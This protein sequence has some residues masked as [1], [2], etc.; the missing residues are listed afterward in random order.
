M[1][2]EIKTAQKIMDSNP[3]SALHLLQHM[4][5]LRM[6]T[7]ADRAIYGIL[8]FQALDKNNKPLQPD[9][10][11]NFSVNY[12][13]A[14]NDKEH[15]ATAYYYKARLY[16]TAQQFD[17]ATMLYLKA[18]D[19]IQNNK[20]LLLRAKIFSD[21][22][23]ICSIQ[24]D[25]KE[26]LV[27]YKESNKWFQLAGDTINA[28]YKIIDVGRVYRLMNQYAKAKENFKN[29]LNQT[30]DSLLQGTAYQELGIN[31]YWAKK[32]DSA[33]YFLRKSLNYPYKGTNYSI[34][35]N[36]MA[37]LNFDIH[38]YDSAI[39]YA[40]KALK[41]PST[42][43]NQRDCY[44][45]LA[46]TEYKRGDFKQMAFY[47]THYQACSDSVRKVEVQTKTTVLE[48]IHQ[49][50]GTISRSKRFILILSFVLP[51][52]LIVS[53]FL[54]YTIRKR[55]KSKEKELEI[56]EVKLVENHVFL[57]DSL[58]QKIA[59]NKSLQA[60]TLKS[61][62]INQKEQILKEIYNVCLHLN[63]WEMFKNLM[64]KTYNNL[65]STLENNYPDLN[66]KEITCCCLF[67]L[68]VPLTEMTIIFESQPGSVY[69][70]KQRIATKLQL[71]SAKDLESVL[72]H[73]SEE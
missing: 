34:R 32:I 37:D 65:V 38:Q 25:Y 3:D 27:K 46:N 36:I 22:G 54:V 7:D 35:C 66:Q 57:K 60:A 26:S 40:T 15:L 28:C 18:L 53:V 24:M 5:P 12:Y 47:M 4:R 20:N 11:I 31:Y 49:S 63:D 9:S 72:H 16:K 39:Y 33:Q 17:N 10:V 48:D 45:I 30:S 1:P 23:D 62:T 2:N 19:L 59:D 41:Y 69:K 8:Y 44:R 52:I 42:Y 13:Q 43:F 6:L 56:A 55:G 51:M 73:L 71:S 67:L 29:A 14:E 58:I 50:N 70:L 64:N 61:S 21:L 68:E